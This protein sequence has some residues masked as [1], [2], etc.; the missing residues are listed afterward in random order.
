MPL[1]APPE[2]VAAAFNQLQLPA[3]PAQRNQTLYQFTQQARA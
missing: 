3:D 1:T 2:E